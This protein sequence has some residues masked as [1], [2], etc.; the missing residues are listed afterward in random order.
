MET[1]FCAR[2]YIL[3]AHLYTGLL[4][5][6]LLVDRPTLLPF[7]NLTCQLFLWGGK[8]LW[9]LLCLFWAAPTGSS[10]SRW[11]AGA[12][13]GR[14]GPYCCLPLSTPPLIR[15]T[16]RG[17]RTAGGAVF[18]G[19]INIPE[20]SQGALQN[21]THAVHFID[22]FLSP[23]SYSTMFPCGQ[24]YISLVG[25][26]CPYTTDITVFLKLW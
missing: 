4:L 19:T 23:V 18:I 7:P 11:A 5:H 15:L 12:R 8:S 24:V 21:Q 13:W 10:S 9:W 6:L 26:Q 20:I 1:W 2:L 14:K 17:L 16:H 3:N 25:N 22:L